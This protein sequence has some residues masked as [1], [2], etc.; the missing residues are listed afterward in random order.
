MASTYFQGAL[1]QG[2]E[3]CDTVSAGIVTSVELGTVSF[4]PA[5]GATNVDLT[6]TIPKNS[7]ILGFTVD[8][9]TAW[10]N[11]AGTATCTIGTTAGG[12]QYVTG[13]DVKTVTRGP[14]AAYTAAQLGAM[15]APAS[16]TV[17]VRV[18]S[19]ATATA[20]TSRVAIELVQFD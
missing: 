9:T 15:F 6:F 2:D 7:R 20:G 5:A 11:G 18:A 10:A 8:T 14:T 3:I 12:T 1:K 4:N 19:S 13:F 17:V 16:Q